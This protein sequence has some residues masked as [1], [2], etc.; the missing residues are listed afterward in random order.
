MKNKIK[1]IGIAA[2][3]AVATS[4]CLAPNTTAKFRM[5]PMT[6]EVSWSNPKDTSLVGL[7]AGVSTNGTRYIKLATLSTLNNPQV[8]TAAGAAQANSITA[9]GTAATQV[10]NALAAVGGTAAAAGATSGLVK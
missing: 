8:I 9:T 5:D 6:G 1:F 10:I 2:L 4:G 7:E 3:L